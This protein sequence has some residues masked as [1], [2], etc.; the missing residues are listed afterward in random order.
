MKS[1]VHLPPFQEKN[2]HCSQNYGIYRVAHEIR[3]E[4]TDTGCPNFPNR[5]SYDEI[6][7]IQS[8]M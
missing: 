4:Y 2:H 7:K 1:A 6:D 3:T 8:I 5:F